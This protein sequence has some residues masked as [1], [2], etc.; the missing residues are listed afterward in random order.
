MEGEEFGSKLNVV[1]S[2]AV[3]VL[4][5]AVGVV[6]LVFFGSVVGI[7]FNAEILPALIKISGDGAVTPLKA[8]NPDKVFSVF[9]KMIYES[10]GKEVTWA[11]LF[12]SAMA[13][14]N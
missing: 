11:V 14:K 10:I 1:A 4:L 6:T 3:I 2:K 9:S 13:P 7:V 8:F 12:E 5:L